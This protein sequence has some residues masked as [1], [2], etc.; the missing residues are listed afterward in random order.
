MA[1]PWEVADSDAYKAIRDDPKKPIPWAW[2][3]DVW[4][5]LQEMIEMLD[6]LESRD[7]LLAMW[8]STHDIEPENTGDYTRARGVIPLDD[9]AL[10]PPTVPAPASG[11]A[12]GD[13]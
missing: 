12:K 5:A 8:D 2:Y 13:G 4:D 11:D 3:C 9:P 1:T 7:A 10:G 6:D